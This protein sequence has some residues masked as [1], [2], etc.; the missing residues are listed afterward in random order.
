MSE[1]AVRREVLGKLTVAMRDGFY[2]CNDCMTTCEREEGE[3][4]QP[5][6]C[7]TCGSHDIQ[8][9]PPAYKRAQDDGVSYE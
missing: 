8:W 6:H 4:G 9:N 3:Q 1:F 7:G 5:A 2:F